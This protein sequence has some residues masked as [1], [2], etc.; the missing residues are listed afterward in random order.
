MNEVEEASRKV[1]E[2]SLWRFEGDAMKALTNP[3]DH[4]ALVDLINE[5]KRLGEHT[6]RKLSLNEPWNMPLYFALSAAVLNRR[7]INELKKNLKI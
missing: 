6:L 4:Q 5:W 1:C 3:E 2:D 7:E